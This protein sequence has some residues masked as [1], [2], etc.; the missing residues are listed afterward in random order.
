MTNKIQKISFITS[1]IVPMSDENIDTDQIMPARFLTSIDKKDFGK[2]LFHDM[3]YTDDGS[4]N[5]DFILNDKKYIKSKILVCGHNFGC[6]SSREHAP[7]GIV[8]YGFSVIISSKFAPIF[9]NNSF[10]NGLLLIKV[11]PKTLN[12]IFKQAKAKKTHKLSIDIKNQILHLN[13]TEV[14]YFDIDPFRKKCLLR[15]LDIQNLKNNKKQSNDLQYLLSIEKKIKE[16]E[17]KR[18]K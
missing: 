4:T 6:G 10:I 15:G 3:R 11:D 9:K 13:N 1:S 2:H 7:W 8:Q 5:P 14:V 16:F 12:K 18:K 17:K